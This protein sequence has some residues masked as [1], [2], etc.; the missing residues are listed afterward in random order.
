MNVKFSWRPPSIMLVSAACSADEA[1][2]PL[3]YERDR[4][5]F[6]HV[7][8]G[9]GFVDEVPGGAGVDEGAR[10]SGAGDALAAEHQEVVRDA[11]AGRRER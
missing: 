11:D 1:A 8:G 6:V 5:T 3:G 7:L 2:D 10:C 9:D 4:R